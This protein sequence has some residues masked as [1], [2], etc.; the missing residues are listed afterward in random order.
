MFRHI[1]YLSVFVIFYQLGSIGHKCLTCKFAWTRDLLTIRSIVCFVADGL[2]CS[3]EIVRLGLGFNALLFTVCPWCR[4]CLC[5]FGRIRRGSSC[6]LVE[7]RW[8]LAGRLIRKC[9]SVSR[10][11]RKSR[12][13][14]TDE[15]YLWSSML[16]L[17]QSFL[18]IF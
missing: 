8:R 18:H 6:C 13:N 11:H 2:L 9:C 7:R 5:R 4:F 10:P 1:Q 16:L 3:W 14:T 17:S 12:Q 15:S